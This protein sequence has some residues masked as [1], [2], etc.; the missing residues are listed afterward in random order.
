MIDW[1]LRAEALEQENEMLRERIGEFEAL[2]KVEWQPPLELA[3]TPSEVQILRLLVAREDIVTRQQIMTFFY[4]LR[5]DV[6]QPEEKIVDVY[7]CKVRAKLRPFGLNV[8]TVWGRGYR[9]SP[10]TRKT[11]LDW[12]VAAAAAR[13]SA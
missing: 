3:L 7:V 5:P 6:E 4:A 1:K 10:E 8:E 12:P 11:L 13:A 9:L 2:L